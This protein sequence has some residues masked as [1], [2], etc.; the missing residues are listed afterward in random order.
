M[1]GLSNFSK[2][3]WDKVTQQIFSEQGHLILWSQ[4]PHPLGTVL[5]HVFMLTSGRT[6][7][8]PCAVIAVASRDEWDAQELLAAKFIAEQGR[9][10]PPSNKPGSGVFYRIGTD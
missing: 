10:V 4:I 7:G 8:Q 9:E 3:D 5:P 6:V 2:I 1:A